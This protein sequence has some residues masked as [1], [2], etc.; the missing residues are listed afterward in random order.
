[1]KGLLDNPVQGLL[2]DRGGGL[3]APARCGGQ[4]TFRNSYDWL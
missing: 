2:H 1:M 3:R 4:R